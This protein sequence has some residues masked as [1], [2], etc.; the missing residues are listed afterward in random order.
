MKIQQLAVRTLLVH[1]MC[2]GMMITTMH[3]EASEKSEKKAPSMLMRKRRNQKKEQKITGA[4]GKST[5]SG[6]QVPPGLVERRV[7]LKHIQL[8]GGLNDLDRLLT[9]N[10]EEAYKNKDILV[11]Q[12]DGA[13]LFG[14]RETPTE[15]HSFARL[16]AT[17]ILNASTK[18][19]RVEVLNVAPHG[20]FTDWTIWAHVLEKNPTI[21]ANSV[22][23]M[24]SCKYKKEMARQWAPMVQ[25]IE[26]RYPHSTVEVR[27]YTTRCV[28][29]GACSKC[30]VELPQEYINSYDV[31]YGYNNELDRAGR[32][33]VWS[34]IGKKRE[35]A[36]GINLGIEHDGLVL[37]TIGDAPLVVRLSPDSTLSSS[38]ERH[39]QA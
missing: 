1:G 13:P 25:W 7:V 12:S 2:V 16:V 27:Y 34:M 32:E 36:V 38:I 5:S 33:K 29:G 15:M 11:A 4:T 26:S 10:P 19:K 20:S 6:Q 23:L 35:D 30:K 28:Q 18:K 14:W 17:S 8:S 22:R 9:S 37:R 3:V 21:H 39:A 24:Y 31:L